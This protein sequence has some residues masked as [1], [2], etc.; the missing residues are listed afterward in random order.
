MP[1]TDAQLPPSQ[2]PASEISAIDAQHIWHPYAAPG[3]PTRV[4]RSTEGIYLSLPTPPPP[5]YRVQPQNN[6]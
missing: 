5:Q 4:V 2:M 6:L 1:D 3:E